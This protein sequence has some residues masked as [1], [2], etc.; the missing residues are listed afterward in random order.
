MPSRELSDN[1]KQIWDG[2]DRMEND[3][4]RELA[5]VYRSALEDIRKE[6]QKLYEKAELEDGKLTRAAAA[7]YNRLENME[8]RIVKQMTDKLAKGG[9]TIDRLASA[10][11]DE[12]FFRYA[13]G[14]EQEAGFDISWGELNKDQVE[15]AVSN[16]LRKIAKQRLRDNGRTVVRRAIAQGLAQGS[17]MRQMSNRVK[18]AI[19]GNATDAMRIARTEAQRSAVLGQQDN[20]NR[21]RN[22]GV[23]VQEI[24]DATLDGRTRPRH[25]N[26]D[27]EPKNE[28][29][30][31][32]YVPGIG[33]I[34]GPMQSG[35]AE[36]DINCRCRVREQIKEYAPSKRR[37]R[38]E[39]IKDYETYE[40]WVKKRAPKRV[41]DRYEKVFG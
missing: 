8:K 7:K 37:Q 23:E 27:G 40:E 16:D 4:E 19:N 32:W 30:N 41:R 34:S 29:K 5:T 15:E 36:F 9:E 25:G 35:V 2:I 20:A 24:W 22:K 26:L 1:E 3:F 13:W 39:G 38:E 33:W 21:A 12:S 18:D 10:Q 31:G 14:I 11:Y 17:T 28:E 6:I